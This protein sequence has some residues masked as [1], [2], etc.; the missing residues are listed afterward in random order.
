MSFSINNL[1]SILDEHLGELSAVKRRN[2]FIETDS[3]ARRP[4]VNTTSVFNYNTKK[5]HYWVF[6]VCSIY[7][8]INIILVFG[9]R[10]YGECDGLYGRLVLLNNLR[11]V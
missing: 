8:P 7:L 5:T 11:K 9:Y 2:C 1:C 6:F 10:L 4:P 3:E